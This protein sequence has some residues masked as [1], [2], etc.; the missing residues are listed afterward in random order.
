M[1]Q[2]VARR[3][4]PGKEASRPSE[5][6]EQDRL[7]LI[8]QGVAECRGTEAGGAMDLA[9]RIEP[10]TARPILD[11]RPLG[12]LR[13]RLDDLCRELQLGGLTFDVLRVL[14]GVRAELVIEVENL[15]LD[16]EQ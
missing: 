11:R 13:D 5:E 8:V 2:E 7:G 12:R 3:L 9:H 15:Q 14:P 4:D 16:L 10:R 1:Q 6:S